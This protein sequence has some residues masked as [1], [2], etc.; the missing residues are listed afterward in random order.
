MSKNIADQV[1]EKLY[2]E[3]MPIDKILMFGEDLERFETLKERN[4]V[5]LEQDSDYGEKQM[6]IF[7]HRMIKSIGIE[8]TEKIFEI[9]N[10]KEKD[11]KKYMTEKNELFQ[12]L[13]NLKFQAQGNFGVTLEIFKALNRELQMYKKDE[14]N[15]NSA[16]MK[17]F[18]ELNKL[19]EEE[20]RRYS[21]K[22]LVKMSM[23][24]AG[25]EI[26]LDNIEQIEEEINAKMTKNNLEKIE[27][28][29]EEKLAENTGDEIGIV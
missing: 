19:L 20:T 10:L 5:Y 12:N 24:R 28:K 1:L 6:D 29:V 18:K 25:Y 13:Y 22:D 21:L 2:S 17:I 14:Q 11:I 27:G 4:K 16:E 26:D 8:E 15:K 3:E 23:E 9:P 7:Y